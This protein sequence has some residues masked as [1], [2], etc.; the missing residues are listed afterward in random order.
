MPIRR[1]TLIF[2]LCDI[3]TLLVQA[4]GSA[5][6]ASNNW[7]GDMVKI[8][9]NVLIGGLALQL[10]TFSF[11]LVIVWCFHGLVNKEGIREGAGNRWK[12]VL[13]AVYVSCSMIVVSNSLPTCLRRKKAE[14]NALK[15]I[16]PL[17]LPFG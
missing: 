7:E 11:F 8:G 13:W 17:H 15:S 9:E 3:L 4:S 6:A 2:V 5:I 12:K 14:T 16:D 1:L 10:V